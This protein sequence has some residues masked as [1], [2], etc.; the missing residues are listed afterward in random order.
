MQKN[1]LRRLVLPLLAVTLTGCLQ[2]GEKEGS[3]VSSLDGSSSVSSSDSSSSVSSVDPSCPTSWNES[4]LAAMKKYLGEGVSVPFPYG[5]S[6]N[7]VE[8]SGT[9]S[10]GVC[11]IVYDSTV[12]DLTSSYCAILEENGFA[13]D[14][15]EEDEEGYYYYCKNVLD[16]TYEL[17]VQTDYYDGDFEIFAWIEALTPQYETFPYEVINEY[18]GLSLSESSFPSF[19]LATDEKYDAYGA[20]DGSY[21]YVGGYFD[22]NTSDDDYLSAYQTALSDKSFVVD[23]SDGSAVNEALGLNVEMMA[24]EGY[25]LIQISKYAVPTPSDNSLSFAATDFPN[26]YPD[27]EELLEKGGFSFYYSSVQ[28]TG[29]YIQFRNA[30]KGSGYLYNTDSLGKIT[31]IV[32]TMNGTDTTYYGVLSLY[33][34]TSKITEPD[35]SK[36]IEPTSSGGVYTYN[37]DNEGGYFLLID[38]ETHASKNDSVLINYSIE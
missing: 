32:V 8:A 33:V 5:V 38:E 37:V 18:F 27:G 14:T 16:D 26:G 24:V 35:A 15:S 23:A 21:F 28:Q 19:V 4:D 1:S 9:D 17:W 3:S 29:G 22:T 30:N 11:F 20:D 6:E 10:D 36:K 13:S 12:G 34:S 25:F 31:S 2:G 7:Y